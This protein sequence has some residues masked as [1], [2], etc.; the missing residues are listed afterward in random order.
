MRRGNCHSSSLSP[1][2]GSKQTSSRVWP[3]WGIACWQNDHC[4]KLERA[5]GRSFIMMLSLWRTILSN[6]ISLAERKQMTN[7]IIGEMPSL[8]LGISMPGIKLFKEQLSNNRA[9]WGKVLLAISTLFQLL[10][11]RFFPTL[12][13]FDPTA[14]LHL[15]PPRPDR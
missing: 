5:R 13:I 3:I 6:E 11:A 15:R 14:F 2:L 7:F 12:N 10:E 4:S 1:A 9:L 8:A